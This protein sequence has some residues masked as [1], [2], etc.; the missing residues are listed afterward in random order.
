MTKIP[1]DTSDNTRR[2]RK[3]SAA[4]L[5]DKGIKPTSLRGS[6]VVRHYFQH[7][8]LPYHRALRLSRLYRLSNLFVFLP[9]VLLLDR[10][11]KRK[12]MHVISAQTLPERNA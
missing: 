9:L 10:T 1:P 4:H 7:L 3:F 5:R 11:S 8:P 12:I 6:G 2:S